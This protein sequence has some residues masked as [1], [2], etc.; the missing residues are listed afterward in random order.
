MALEVY[1]HSIRHR[2]ND[3]RRSSSELR[4]RRL[5]IEGEAQPVGVPS[6]EAGD[7]HGRLPQG[8][9]RDAGVADRCAARRRRSLH[10]GYALAEVG[11][12]RRRLLTGGPGPD[13][14]HVEPIVGSHPNL[15]N[16]RLGMVNSSPG[17]GPCGG[18][19]T[20]CAVSDALWVDARE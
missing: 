18:R 12:L 3:V 10:D 5:R 15:Q 19:R 9:T 8:F 7:V 6:T 17:S 4:Q 1:A 14:H 16:A 13:D 20:A 2:L 11:R